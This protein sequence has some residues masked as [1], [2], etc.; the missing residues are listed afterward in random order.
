LELSDSLLL[1]D[2]LQLTG[3]LPKA[4]PILNPDSLKNLAIRNRPDLKQ[5]YWAKQIAQKTIWRATASFMPKLSYT[6]TNSYQ[7]LSNDMDMFNIAQDDWINSSSSQF[8]LSIPIFTGLKN[9]TAYLES[10]MNR[11]QTNYYYDEKEKQVLVDVE[12][13]AYSLQVALANLSVY[14]KTLEQ[15]RESYRQANLLY[16]QQGASQLDLITAQLGLTQAESQYYQGIVNCNQ[17]YDQLQLSI[18][19]IN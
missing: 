16:Q 17:A 12:K 8:S 18:G 3:L 19:I 11:A 7:A 15:A 6:Y 1:L 5:L 9:S 2:T 4:A 14:A 13:A 10:R